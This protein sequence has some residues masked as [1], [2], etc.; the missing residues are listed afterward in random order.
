MKIK[1]EIFNK[2]NLLYIIGIIIFSILFAIPSIKYMLV[3]KTVLNFKNEFC[4]LLDNSNRIVQTFI[5]AVILMGFLTFYYFIIKNRNKIFKN[6]KQVFTLIFIVSSIFIFTIPFMSSDVFYYLGIGRLNSQYG[7][8][9]YYVTM[10]QY[11]E[12]E[13][14]N[15]DNDTVM[16][17]GYNSYWADTTVVYG[18]IW[19]LICS[20]ISMLSLGNINFGLLLFKIANLL[21]HM[22]CTYLIYKIS[23][24]KI[25]ALL[26][27]LNP[28]ILIEG[29]VN[30]HNDIFVILFILLAFYQLIKKKNLLF[31]IASLAIA[32]DIKYFAV[33][34]LP[35]FVI[36]YYR[37]EKLLK[38]TLMCMV[39]GMIFALIVAIPYLLYIQDMQVFM[40]INTQRGKITKGLYLFIS[41]YF[42]YPQDLCNML[43]NFALYV[44]VLAYLYKCLNLLLNSKIIFRNEM[45][46]LYLFILA[47]LF[48]L[49][50]N[51]Q[52]WY[53]IW[54]SP[55]VIWQKSKNIKLIIQMQILTLFSNMVFLI[56]SENYVYGVP[57]F[58][59]FVVGTLI[60]MLY[61]KKEKIIYVKEGK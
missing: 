21:A 34:L 31:S 30:V 16:Q 43:S 41:Q 12:N 45:Q 58:V 15:I 51:F 50:T 22:I 46:H 29:L 27:G 38:R 40:G 54:L 9:P 6:I 7:Q 33:L 17:E 4:F 20:F 59:T 2:T 24:K 61:N 5:Y 47:F 28:F 42:T 19:T 18:P 56:Y 60:C 23:K 32:T 3:N 8:N 10:K 52:P 49:I 48:L 39:N 11:V 53:L 14:L 44:F 55:F 57:F 35:F 36:Y 37:N 1:K 26:Y 25:F 13:N